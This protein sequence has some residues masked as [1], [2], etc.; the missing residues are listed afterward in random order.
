MDAIIE[1]WN[2]PDW[3]D[4]WNGTREQFFE[5]YL[6]AYRI[7]RA[8]LGPNVQIAGPSFG[9]YDRAAIEAFLEYC[10]ANGC[11]VNSLT[12]HSLDD[13]PDGIGTLAA[14]IQ[15]ARASFVQNPRYSS[16]RMQRIDINEVVGPVY[17]NQPAGTL[18]H[19]EG[20][21]RGGADA[22][23]HA[24]WNDSDGT[25]GCLNRTING[26]LTPGAYE[27]RAVWWLHRRTSTAYE[28]AFAARWRTIRADSARSP[29]PAAR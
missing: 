4:F 11:E 10:L 17:T 13:G 20:V 9:F 2:E 23:A 15:D 7:L 19:Y 3:P 21:E 29:W 24:C 25:S 28:A 18:A 1:I 5:T 14:R 8:E 12:W 16:L 6:R 22:A 26:L 27:P